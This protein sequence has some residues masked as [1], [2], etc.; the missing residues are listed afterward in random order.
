M[1][2]VPVAVPWAAQHTQTG[3]AD[4]DQGSAWGFVSFCSGCGVLGG[5]SGFQ[6]WCITLNYKCTEWIVWF[7]GWGRLI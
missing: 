7:G 5:R 2:L 1:A 6:G 3:T 4:N